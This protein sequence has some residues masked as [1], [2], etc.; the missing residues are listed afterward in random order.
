M[1]KLEKKIRFCYMYNKL[2]G[3]LN[4]FRVPLFLFQENVTLHFPPLRRKI[5][6]HPMGVEILGSLIDNW[7]K[8]F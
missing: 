6:R 1:I 2:P 5:E 3:F 8:Q 7:L 4:N